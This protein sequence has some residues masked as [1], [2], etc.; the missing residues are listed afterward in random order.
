MEA[1]T[2]SDL[3]ASIT[4]GRP[5]ADVFAFAADPRND[6]RWSGSS[7]RAEIVQGELGVGAV[8]EVLLAPEGL[9][10]DGVTMLGGEPFA[11]P[12]ALAA[13]LRRLKARGEHTVV[14]SGYTLEALRRRP[15]A[16]VREAL[17]CTDLLIDGPY[18]AALADEAGEWR[19]SRNQEFATLA[20]AG[21]A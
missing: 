8:V 19:G 13:L 6:P 2:M 16:A 17:A 14:Y 1:P 21:D 7:L 15:E 5:V 3:Q 10:R 4:I 18:V 12:Q 11:Q 20:V 9:P